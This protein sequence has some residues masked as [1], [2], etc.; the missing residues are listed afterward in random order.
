MM[1]DPLGV[2]ELHHQ[3][4]RELETTLRRRLL[5]ACCG[6]IDLRRTWWRTTVERAARALA[7]RGWQ[8]RRRRAL[9]TCC[10]A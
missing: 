9:A 5:Q 7:P 6:L 4:E 2:L 1:I 8:A 3:R 10:P